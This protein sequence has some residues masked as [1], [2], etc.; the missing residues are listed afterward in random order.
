MSNSVQVPP[1][2]FDDLTV[3]EQIDYVQELWNR[4]AA[5]PEEVPVPDWHKKLVAE[6]L[7]EHRDNPS[8]VSSLSEVRDRIEK[9]L[10]AKSERSVGSYFGLSPNS[11][12]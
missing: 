6:R 2:G 7:R 11:T 5:R 9:E 10:R 3:D 1:P 8:D 12:S 4:I